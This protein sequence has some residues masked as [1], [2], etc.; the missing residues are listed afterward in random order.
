MT[1][2]DPDVLAMKAMGESIP[3][4]DE[5]HI[6]QCAS[7]AS[8][9]RSLLRVADLARSG[10]PGEQLAAPDDSVWRRI[11]ATLSFPS[12]VVPRSVAARASGEEVDAAASTTPPVAV[13]LAPD[14]RLAA[15]ATTAA[16][17]AAPEAAQRHDTEAGTTPT[18]AAGPVPLHDP[19]RR[20]RR[21]S[22]RSRVP[23]LLAAAAAAVIVGGT[24]AVIVSQLPASPDVLAEA[25][26]EP[27][28]DW[29]GSTGDALLEQSADGPREVVVTLD[30]PEADGAYREVWLIAPDLSG[31][32]SIGVLS[33]TE[34]RFVVPDG[35]DIA[36]YPIVD[37]SA[38]PL[39]GNPE[40]S[41]DSIVRG[42]LE[43]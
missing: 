17:T 29:S 21:A 14:P 18:A 41:G 1:H 9:L 34:G 36:D 19:Q 15:P 22:R 38:E 43:S 40:H 6:E 16:T 2:S 30:A 35:I 26:L 4:D 5:L 23:Y 39:D 32:I 10:T 13:D 20:P 42:S 33:G 25:P 28:P 8:E 31:L 24:A 3:A 11:S 7:C 37:V 12:D 27:L